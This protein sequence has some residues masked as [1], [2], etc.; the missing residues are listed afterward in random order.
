MSSQAIRKNNTTIN[1]HN[2]IDKAAASDAIVACRTRSS[3]SQCERITLQGT[4][5]STKPLARNRAL[6]AAVA[7]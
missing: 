1:G 7:T 4:V 6:R 5:E 3:Q 2:F